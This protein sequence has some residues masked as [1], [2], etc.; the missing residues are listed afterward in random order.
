MMEQNGAHDI[1]FADRARGGS[2]DIRIK[3]H[4]T[5]TSPDA[6]TVFDFPFS[7]SFLLIQ[8]KSLLKRTL[9]D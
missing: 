1:E 7:K 3:M 6:K 2:C 4:S 9:M 8:W 5:T